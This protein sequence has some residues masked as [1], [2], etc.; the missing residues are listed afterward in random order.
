MATLNGTASLLPPTIPRKH[1]RTGPTTKYAYCVGVPL[2][3]FPGLAQPLCYML[4]ALATMIS[5]IC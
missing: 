2:L 5:E 1:L 4:P 3:H